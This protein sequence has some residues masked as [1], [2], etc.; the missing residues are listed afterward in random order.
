MNSDRLSGRR[1]AR[2]AAMGPAVRR[3]YRADRVRFAGQR[4]DVA[5]L[6]DS[7]EARARLGRAGPGR[8]Q[9]LCDPASQMNPLNQV[10]QTGRPT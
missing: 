9:K 3:F 6:I 2:G 1:S 5:D 8:A 7:P 4:R 10:A